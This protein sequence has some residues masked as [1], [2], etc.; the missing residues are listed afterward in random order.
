MAANW[1]IYS[2]D[3]EAYLKLLRLFFYCVDDFQC[4]TSNPRKLFGVD[5]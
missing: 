2:V 5:G 3:A 4:V 1:I